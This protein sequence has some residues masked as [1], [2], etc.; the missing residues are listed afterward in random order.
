MYTLGV[1]GVCQLLDLYEAPDRLFLVTELCEGGE[2]YNHVIERAEA[3]DGTPFSEPDAA[4]IM[5]QVGA[6]S[7]SGGRYSRLFIFHVFV[8]FPF[9]ESSIAHL[10]LRITSSQFYCYIFFSE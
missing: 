9:L 6:C 5:K 3:E 1:P 7:F 10:F 8:P 2:L 4:L